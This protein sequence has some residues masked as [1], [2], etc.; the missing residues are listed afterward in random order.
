MGQAEAAGNQVLQHDGILADT[1]SSST[2][3][4]VNLTSTKIPART[5]DQ[6]H[7]VPEL[8]PYS[9][10][11]SSTTPSS[12]TGPTST[13]QTASTRRDQDTSRA[14]GFFGSLSSSFKAMTA[15]MRHKPEPFV[16]PLCEAATRGD[17]SQMQGLLGAGANINGYNEAGLTPLVCAVRALQVDAL[18]YLL[19]TGADPKLSSSGRK[20]KPPLYYAA[21][22]QCEPALDALLSSGATMA[23]SDSWF[24]DLVTGEASSKSIAMLLARG[25]NVHA[26]D[27]SS[28]SAIVLTVHYRKKVEDADE[29]VATLLAHGADP[30][31]QDLSGTPLVHSCLQQDRDQLLSLLIERGASIN[32]T[33]MYGNSLAIEALKREKPTLVKTLISRGANVNATDNY[34]IPLLISILASTSLSIADKA[35]LVELL[36]NK[37]ARCSATD[38]CAVTALDHA[39][40]N[41]ASKMGPVSD[42]DLRIIGLLLGHGADANQRLSKQSGHP[43]LLTYSLD[44][45][46]WALLRV[47]LS[48]GAQ[49]NIADAK[50]RTPL[51]VAMQHG[52]LDI[53]ALLIQKG[54]DK[55][56]AGQITPF[57]MASASRD[58]RMMQLLGV[59]LAVTCHDQEHASL[60]RGNT[61]SSRSIS[62]VQDSVQGVDVPP[63]YEEHVT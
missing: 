52:N 46:D 27:S 29:V 3:P 25:A 48:G 49:P 15:G 41:V 6:G 43:N 9:V 8:P 57:E 33:N 55:N 50:G 38:N 36:V 19:R 54:A 45:Q 56:Q 1:G 17:V 14:E 10:D 34:G 12:S 4:D 2:N 28:R 59:P 61:H 39:V 26:K 11:A 63:R 60:D 42:A 20:G 5:G 13:T 35:D 62:G 30:N 24:L 7:S 22:A 58:L 16:V 47:A 44:R 37:G 51:L 53:V 21:L 23:D 32:R 31:A 40:A 18:R